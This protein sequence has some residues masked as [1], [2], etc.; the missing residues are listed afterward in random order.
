MP[1]RTRFAG[2]ESMSA[3]EAFYATLMHELTHWTGHAS[4]CARCQS[5]LKFD[6]LS[7]CKIDPLVARVVTEGGRSPTGVTM[8]AAA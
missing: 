1:D 6:P 8:R 5:A 7:A 3:G 2:S 4:R